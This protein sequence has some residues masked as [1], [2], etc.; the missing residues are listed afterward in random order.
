MQKQID[1]SILDDQNVT[2][3]KLKT[4]LMKELQLVHILVS[5]LL[6]TTEVTDAI[7]DVFYKRYLEK[8]IK[9]EVVN[10]G[11]MTTEEYNIITQSNL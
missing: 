7:V 11:V 4:E 1:N 9:P 5:E 3:E 10:Q 8:V 2:R 6:T